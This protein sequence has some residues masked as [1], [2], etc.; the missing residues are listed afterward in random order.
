MPNTCTNLLLLDGPAAEIEAFRQAFVS[1]DAEDCPRL[2]FN[3]ILPMPEEIVVPTPVDTPPILEGKDQTWLDW[4]TR[5]WGSKWNGT[6]G[7]WTLLGS[8]LAA[9]S[10]DT[11]WG[12]PE[13][14]FHALARDARMAGLTAIVASQLEAFAEGAWLGQ[15]AE[16]RF[17]T[18]SVGKESPNLAKAFDLAN[19]PRVP[20]HILRGLDRMQATLSRAPERAAAPA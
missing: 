3:A 7:R 15:I 19:P 10:F 2:D 5:A 4:R 11:P 20:V 14:A 6:N 17:T 1:F 8:Q 9:L 13:G 12:P 18:S 16:G